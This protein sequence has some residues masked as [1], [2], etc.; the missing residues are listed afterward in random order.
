MNY[1]TKVSY[2]KSVMRIIG[3]VG[4]LFFI[5]IAV[6]ILI[7]AELLGIIEEF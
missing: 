6:L 5:K 7:G 4:L 2:I 3:F 1:H